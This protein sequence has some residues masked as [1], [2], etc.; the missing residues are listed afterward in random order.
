MVVYFEIDSLLDATSSWCPQFAKAGN[1]KVAEA[2]AGYHIKTIKLRG[3]LSQGLVLPLN[4][5][6]P[7]IWKCSVDELTESLDVTQLLGVTK[8][9]PPEIASCGAAGQSDRG[10]IPFPTHLVDKTDETR[11]QSDPKLLQAIQGLPYQM[12][13]KLDG[14]SAT[15]VI[16]PDT[17]AF[18]VC[19]RNQVCDPLDPSKRPYFE[20][21]AKY[22]IEECLRSLMCGIAALD[23]QDDILAIGSTSKDDNVLSRHNVP[24]NVAI[25]GEICGPKIQKNPLGLAE[26]DFFVFNVVDI[27]T[28]QRL[29]VEPFCRAHGFRHVFLEEQGDAFSYVSIPQLL[30][31]AEGKYPGTKTEREGLVVRNQDGRISF[32]V[33]SNAFLLQ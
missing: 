19:S 29:P 18:L 10:G 22:N 32:K 1:V 27:N 25:Q 16:D 3:E 7:S 6:E 11:I 28:K 26:T 14:T 2:N 9:D 33:I 24:R 12:T 21:A 15:F 20:M 31:K 23:N 8:Y 13:V 5:F 17:K 4:H 30:A